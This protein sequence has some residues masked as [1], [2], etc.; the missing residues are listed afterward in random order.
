MTS[1]RVSVEY[2]L[3]VVAMQQIFYT[4][5]SPAEYQRLGRDFPFPEPASCPNPG[6]RVQVPLQKHGFYHRNVLAGDFSGRIFI[7]RYYCKYCGKT[8]SLL[9]S[10]CLPYFQYSVELIYIVLLYV[11]VS[12][13][14]LRACLQLLKSRFQHLYWDPGHLQF[15][16]GRFLANLKRI[17]VGLRE[18]IPGVS[19]P[20]D[21]MDKRKG[22]QEVLRIVATGFPRIQTFSTRFFAQCRHSFMAPVKL[23]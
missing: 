7:R 19:L 4:P 12:T 15:Y 9:P 14:S 1:I 2:L 18:L 16:T 21:S 17:K 10:F 5:V 3:V 6:C 20:E 22:A 23:F 8:V 13:H 11:L